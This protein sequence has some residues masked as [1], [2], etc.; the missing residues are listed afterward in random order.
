MKRKD[1]QAH[2]AESAGEER[3]TD[4]VWPR[5]LVEL[6]ALLGTP[7]ICS[8]QTVESSRGCCTRLLRVQDVAEATEVSGYCVL[9]HQLESP[10]FLL[11]FSPFALFSG[12]KGPPATQWTLRRVFF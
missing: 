8:A 5:C 4:A 9:Q 1:A 7:C 11:C 12:S 6:P 2:G 10:H 3:A